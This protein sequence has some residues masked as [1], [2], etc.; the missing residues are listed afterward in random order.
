MCAGAMVNG[1]ARAPRLRRHRSEGR[2]G[3][4][5]L[6]SRRQPAP[7][8]PRAA[9]RRRAGRGVRAAAGRLL[10]RSASGGSD[11]HLRRSAPAQ[12]ADQPSQ[13]GRA[14]GLAAR[15]RPRLGRP[16]PSPPVADRLDRRQVVEHRRAADMAAGARDWPPRANRCGPRPDRAASTGSASSAVSA[17]WAIAGVVGEPAAGGERTG[18]DRGD[19]TAHGEHD[20]VG[21]RL[22]AVLVTE[23]RLERVIGGDVTSTSTCGSTSPAAALGIVARAAADEPGRDAGPVDV[24]VRIGLVGAREPNCSSMSPLGQISS[25]LSIGSVASGDSFTGDASGSLPVLGKA[26]RAEV[27]DPVVRG[28]VLDRQLFGGDRRRRRKV[29]VIGGRRPRAAASPSSTSRRDRIV[30]VVGVGRRGGRRS[31]RRRRSA[32]AG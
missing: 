9:H 15:R 16:D 30:L 8:P 6:R 20:V 32:S 19:G 10:R 5:P 13:G 31:G 21:D 24:G 25:K 18:V 27:F 4:K 12:A 2:R 23:P 11:R 17:G 29:V 7:Q 26:G 22:P 14:V 1:T 3:R 28:I